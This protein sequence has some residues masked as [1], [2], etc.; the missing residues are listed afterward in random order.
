[1]ME[2]LE[3]KVIDLEVEKVRHAYDKWHA[4]GEEWIEAT[5]EM[6]KVLYEA[7][8]RFKDT[9][10]FAA[11]LQMNE[12]IIS[13]DDRVGFIGM[14]G[15][16]DAA[17]AMLIQTQSRSI[18]HTWRALKSRVR[19]VSKSKSRPKKKVESV[20][21]DRRLLAELRR[22]R[23]EAHDV[24]ITRKWRPEGISVF[25]LH[26]IL[27]WVESQLAEFIKTRATSLED[28]NPQ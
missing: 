14:G 27:D 19:H 4:A 8:S 5:L 16:I 15:N 6:A 1:M 28:A 9:R 22:R 21:F 20:V 17:R 3:N 25:S 18:N 10:E 24:E 12:I 7:K 13:K 26:K 11:W 23:K 2:A